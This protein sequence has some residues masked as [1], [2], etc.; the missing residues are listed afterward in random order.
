MSLA[1]NCETSGSPLDI[2]VGKWT[3]SLGSYLEVVL[4]SGGKT[5]SVTKTSVNGKEHLLKFVIRL[6]ETGQKPRISWGQKFVLDLERAAADE[7]EWLHT[8]FAPL[9]AQVLRA[10]LDDLDKSQRTLDSLLP[11]IEHIYTHVMPE[12][13]QRRFV[14]AW[15]A[16]G[17]AH[18]DWGVDLTNVVYATAW[19]YLMQETS[20][21]CEARSVTS[22]NGSGNMI[23]MVLGLMY[24]VDRLPLSLDDFHA[25][26]TRRQLEWARDYWRP[27]YLLLTSWKGLGP[28]R[29]SPKPLHRGRAR[30]LSFATRGVALAPPRT[31][32]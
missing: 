1:G 32:C 10:A 23:E 14:A 16:V 12:E 11:Y 13:K 8:G 29:A 7:L 3:D 20:L 27:T 21:I 19:H 22:L 4:D 9:G 2:V 26:C 30:K 18:G 6:T 28:I 15:G 5:C 25:E 24:L 17:Q 31:V